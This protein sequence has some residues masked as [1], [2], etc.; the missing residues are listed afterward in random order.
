MSSSN[1][2]HVAVAVI[3]NQH[4]QF[5]IAKRPQDSHQGGLW[6]FPGGKIENNESVLEA[7]K[8]E[9]FEEIGVTLIQATPLIRIHHDYGDKTV[10]LDVWSVV[11]FSGEAFS[12]EGQKTCWAKQDDFRL[13]KFPAANLAIIKAIQLPSKYMITGKFNDEDELISRIQTSLNNGI[14]LIQFRANHLDEKI[15]FEYAK[16]IFTDCEDKNAKLLLNT[17]N[18]NYKKYKASKFSHGLHLNS[19]EIKLFSPCDKHEDLLFSTSTHNDEEIRLAEIKNIDFILLSPV[20][21]TLSHPNSKPLG[22][23][24]FKQLTDNA[25][26]PVYALGG[27]SESDLKI[28]KEHGGQGISAIGA[29]WDV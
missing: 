24:N 6:E 3:Q 8:R 22:W 9:L 16:R 1:I 7:L 2:V 5:L 12:K 23:N 26:I 28:S 14:K 20:K 15:Y 10:L 19:K 13:Y 11:E 29:F 21:K 4:G 17:S 18:K 27:M 25:N